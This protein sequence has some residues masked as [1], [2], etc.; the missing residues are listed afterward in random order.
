M[1]LFDSHTHLDAD[2]F[3]EDQSAV[4]ERALAAGVRRIVTIGA[5]EGFKSADRAIALAEKYDFIW[6]SAGIHPHDA[7]TPIDIK[8]LESLLLHPRVVAV[9]ETGLDYFKEWSPRELQDRWFRAQ[10][11]LALSVKK[12][13][14]IH[15][16]EA[17]EQCLEILRS[18]HA[19]RV[20]GVFHCYSEDAAFAEKL[21]EINF[22]VSIPGSITFKKAEKL[23]D[24]V[25]AIPLAQIMLET[26]APYLAP[27]P[28][29]GK[30]CESS[31][32]VETALA[33]AKIKAVSV[34]HV[35]QVTTSTASTF[36]KIPVPSE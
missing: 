10:I 16:R 33:V 4:I 2:A 31:Q 30:R 32:M 25:K 17:A 8:A 23:R 35:A 27:E 7:A 28:H 36:F 9:G 18:Y 29:R 20:G 24:A 26:D 12:P 15:S 1:I 19:E 6:A 34:E 11:E 21:K 5:S 3:K 14:I 13:L 22:L